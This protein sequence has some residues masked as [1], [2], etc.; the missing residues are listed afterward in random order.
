[1]YSLLDG[2]TIAKCFE[3]VS[4]CG[5]EIDALHESLEKLL[6]EELSRNENSLPCVNV[7]DKKCNSE[8][9]TDDSGWVYTDFS[10]SIPLKTKGR[11]RN[12]EKYLS[13]QI[14]LTGDGILR[15]GNDAGEPLLHVCLWDEPICFRDDYYMG[16]PFDDTTESHKIIANHL[17]DWSKESENDWKSRTWTFSIRLVSLKSQDDLQKLIVQPMLNLLKLVSV[18]EALPN[19]LHG[20]V[21]YYEVCLTK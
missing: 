12:V 2:L 11:K 7:M 14:S 16:F 10:F 3:V 8:Y 6:L 18:E 5:N 1:M 9:R 17:I 19:S 13:C 15:N 21:P 20:L 4:R